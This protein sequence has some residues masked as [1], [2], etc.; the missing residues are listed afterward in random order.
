MRPARTGIDR[1]LPIAVT[2]SRVARYAPMDDARQRDL[3]VRLR[4]GEL[5]AFDEVYDSLRARVFTFLLRLSGR[6][7]VAEDLVQEVW[8]RLARAAPGLA[9][10]TQLSAWLFTVAR[11]LFVS[12]WRAGQ[13]A[14]ALGDGLLPE[15]PGTPFQAAADG[16][17]QRRLEAALAG[18]PIPYREIVLLCGVE[19]MAPREAAAALEITPEAARQRL[20]RARAMLA[21]ELG[22]EP[23]RR[24]VR[25][26]TR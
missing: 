23:G 2:M 3:V 12:H 18:L 7:D 13:V 24:Q 6:R 15:A 10:D 20:A 25:G 17:T 16:E 22:P 26:G 11:N 9:L 8:L 19:G 5:G 21:A 1:D 4:R 14:Q